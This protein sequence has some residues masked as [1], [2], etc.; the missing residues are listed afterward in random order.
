MQ[1]RLKLL[2]V[3]VAAIF[4]ARQVDAAAIVSQTAAVPAMSATASLVLGAM[5]M[6]GFHLIRRRRR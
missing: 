6:A 3:V 5:A 1:H 4:S 2:T